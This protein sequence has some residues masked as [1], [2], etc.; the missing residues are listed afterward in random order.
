[1]TETQAHEPTEEKRLIVIRHAKTE[2]LAAND[3]ARGL[4]DRGRRDAQALGR[5]L[6]DA[7][8]YPD[9]VL[10]SSATRAQQTAEIVAGALDPV[11]QVLSL[12]ELYGAS[13][14]DVIELCAQVPASAKCAAVVG[15][16]PTM[17]MLASL[18]LSDDAIIS[19]F[20]TSAAAVIDLPGPWDG[21]SEDSG[22]LAELHTPDDQ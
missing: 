1:M 7:S 19:H 17:V 14:P 12:D 3:H 15:H 13:P 22:T 10:V 11:P 9:V 21:L 18:L 20:P 6:A 16:N 2:Q 8:I 5:W 4:T